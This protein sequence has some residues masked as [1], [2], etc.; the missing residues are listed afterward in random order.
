MKNYVGCL[1]IC[2]FAIHVSSLVKYLFRSVPHILKIRCTE[3]YEFSKYLSTSLLSDTCF[4]GV[5]S[6]SVLSIH[7]LNSVY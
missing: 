6:H 5:F 2:L 3:F 1:F 4:A 7:S